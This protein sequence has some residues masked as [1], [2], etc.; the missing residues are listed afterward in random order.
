MVEIDGVKEEH[1]KVK[2]KD[3]AAI[4]NLAR[5]ILSR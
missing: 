1:T 5:Y 2:S 4:K 3:D